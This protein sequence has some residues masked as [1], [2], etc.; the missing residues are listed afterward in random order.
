MIGN[1][2]IELIYKYSNFLIKYSIE[3]IRKVIIKHFELKLILKKISKMS[4]KV[5]INIYIHD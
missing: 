5:I 1:S 2:F 3:F 4:K